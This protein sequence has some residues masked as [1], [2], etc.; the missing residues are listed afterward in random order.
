MIF[1]PSSEHSKES[2][3]DNLFHKCYPMKI[4]VKDKFSKWIKV[5]ALKILNTEIFTHSHIKIRI[6]NPAH[7]CSNFLSFIC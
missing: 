4:F 6:D 7:F 5:V 3:I 2:Y 1:E